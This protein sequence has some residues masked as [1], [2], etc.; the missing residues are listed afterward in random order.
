MGESAAGNAPALHLEPTACCICGSTSAEPVAVGEDFEYRTSPDSFLAVRC[1]N[2][3]L[4]Y[5]DP[6]PAPESVAQIYPDSYHAFDFAEEGFGLVYR[7]RSR[8]EARR[9]LKALSHVGPS[10]RILDVGCGDGFH[11]SLIR[12]FGPPGWTLEGIDID[13]RAV[14][15]GRRRGLVIHQGTVEDIDLPDESYDA[16]IM[17]QTI[18]HVAS[19][20]GVLAA[21]RRLLRPGGTL[22]IVTDNTG[23]LDF[24]MNHRRYWGGYHFPR[25]WN[26]FNDR[27]LRLLAK[28][29]DFDVVSFETMVSPVNWTYSVRNALDDAGAPR[30]MVNQ[31]SLQTPISLA[32]FT[33]FDAVHTALGRGALLRVVLARPA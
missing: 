25:H 22:L 8:L 26:L 23:S 27:S 13:P 10:G 7:V 15:A 33:A 21:V 20:P 4:I 18:E 17:I 28:K 5:L 30:W 3:D 14:E 11:L 16:A 24:R 9:M 12:E 32:A 2:C 19:P 31:F 29:V 6:R 1:P